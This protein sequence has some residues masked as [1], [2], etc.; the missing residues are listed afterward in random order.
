MIWKI[1]FTSI[2]RFSHRVNTEMAN[3][4]DKSEFPYSLTA[5]YHKMCTTYSILYEFFKYYP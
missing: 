3:F 1:V 2:Y 5:I 4:R